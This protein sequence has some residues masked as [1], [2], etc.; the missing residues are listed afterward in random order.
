MR[1]Q[2]IT[3]ICICKSIQCNNNLQLKKKKLL[4][5]HFTI[6]KMEIKLEKESIYL[7]SRNPFALKMQ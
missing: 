2:Y 7:F 5:T 3:V 4:E 1:S 6:G